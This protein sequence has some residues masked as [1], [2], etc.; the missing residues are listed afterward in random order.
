[1]HAAERESARSVAGKDGSVVYFAPSDRDRRGGIYRGL[2]QLFSRAGIPRGIVEGDVVAI[3]VHF[4][5]LGN[6]RYL[7]PVLVRRLVELVRTAGGRPFVTDTTTL[8]RHHRHD[9]FSHLDNARANG[10]TPETLGCP[11]LIADGIRS[12]GVKVAVDSNKTITTVSVAQAIF[13]ADVLVNAAHLTFHHE[14]TWAG[15]VKA[16]GMGCTTKQM[17]LL[18][19]APSG[20][21]S[22][23]EQKCTKCGLCLKYC[24]GDAFQRQGGRIV[25]VPA[26]CLGCGDCFGFCTGEAIDLDWGGAGPELVRRTAECARGVLCTFERGKAWH[27]LFAVDIAANC[28]CIGESS[29]DRALPDLGVLVSDDPVAVDL[30]AIHLADHDNFAARWQ[31]AARRFKATMAETVLAAQP[32]SIQTI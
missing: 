30:A 20:K 7:R 18:M 17:K 13:D 5:E 6:T 12:N 32:Y 25:L 14:F 24:P 29:G 22:F 1:M 4:G 9:L 11:V 3:K 10:F 2:K 27:L 21:P 23:R 15:A 8:Y 26:S 28:D 16:L 31:E 19:H